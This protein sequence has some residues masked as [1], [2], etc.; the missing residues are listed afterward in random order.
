[1]RWKEM[2]ARELDLILHLGSQGCHGKPL[3]PQVALLCPQHKSPAHCQGRKRKWPG[4]GW[5]PGA[6]PGK[7]PGPLLG[8]RKRGRLPGPTPWEEHGGRGWG[9][10]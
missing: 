8:G 5:Q 7:L 3:R 6:E 1:M 2:R 4:Q 9:P 10:P